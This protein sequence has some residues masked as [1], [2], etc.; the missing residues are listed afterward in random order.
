MCEAA[1]VE[2]LASL[3]PGFGAVQ[4][5]VHG[6]FHTV[7]VGDDHVARVLLGTNQ[8]SRAVREC[9]I[10]ASAPGSVGPVHLPQLVEGPVTHQGRT[11]YLVT[12]VPGRSRDADWD[13][14]R[15]PLA[16]LLDDL[17]QLPRPDALPPVRSWCGGD[18]LV[19]IVAEHFGTRLGAALPDAVGLVDDLDHLDVPGA[20]FVHGDFGPHNLLW[21][22]NRISG[23][24]DLDHAC[25][26]DPAIDLAPLVGFFG[27][28]RVAEVT[29]RSTLHRAMRHRATLSLQVA[30]AAHLAG[31]D[32]LR[33]HA[34]GNFLT[35]HE[36]G[37]LF[38]PEGSL[39]A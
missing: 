14:L 17:A 16:Q 32:G 24:V 37:T 31:L 20:V 38:D 33:D 11:G 2:H 13:E 21:D 1:I 3:F 5:V 7:A 6:A 26:G 8:Q 25:F 23:L 12:R 19:G 4:S 10:L 35:R 39:P 34:L 28:S 29:D 9:A 27:A 15:Q 22:G 30:A 18:A 36:Q